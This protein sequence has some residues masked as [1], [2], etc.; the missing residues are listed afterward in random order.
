MDKPGRHCSLW[1]LTDDALRR[2]RQSTTTI[3]RATMSAMKMVR[4]CAAVALILFVAGWSKPMKTSG[5]HLGFEEARALFGG[6][7]V[8]PGQPLPK[9][10]L[11]DLEGKPVLIAD[12]QKNRPLVLVTASITCN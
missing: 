11:V 4:L 2:R 3:S 9:L 12:I 7:G 5:D 6:R 10:S 8:Q 1:Q